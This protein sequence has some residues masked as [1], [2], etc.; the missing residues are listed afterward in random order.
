MSEKELTFWDH[1]DEF[2][3]VLFRI[4]IV[5][6]LFAIV[7]FVCK[8]TLFSIVLA[9]HRSDFVL[10]RLFALL[11]SELSMPSLYPREF[12]V[13]LISVQLT[14]QF[15]IHT[16]AAIYAGVLLA[17]PYIIYQLF[18][19]ISPAL[20]DNERKYSF[21]VIAYSFILFFTGVLLNYFLIFPLSF[22]FLASHQVTEEVT[23]MITLASYMD[24]LVMLSLMMG[25]MFELPIISWLLAKLGILTDK[26]MKTYRKHAVIAILVIAAVITPSGDIFTLLIVSFPIYLLYELSISIVRRT[27]KSVSRKP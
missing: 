25:I 5:V 10:Y 15:I 13:D 23:N 1:L 19:F 24:T 17:S 22:R 20:Y 11:A 27:Q 2:K 7:A 4:L 8:E 18:R 3:K 16:T 6:V 21:R 14:S 9:P 12:H 26:Y